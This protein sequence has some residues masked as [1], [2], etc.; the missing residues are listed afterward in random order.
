MDRP[1]FF[2]IDSSAVLILVFRLLRCYRALDLNITLRGI[3]FWVVCR[4]TVRR[5]SLLRLHF[6]AQLRIPSRLSP[7]ELLELVHKEDGAGSTTSDLGFEALRKRLG[8]MYLRKELIVLD[9]CLFEER[10]ISLP[11]VVAHEVAHC[12][13]EQPNHFPSDGNFKLHRTGSDRIHWSDSN[14]SEI[15]AEGKA[16]LPWPYCC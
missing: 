7:A 1:K 3:P 9:R 10:Q 12:D 6:Q 13:M 15:P 5:E 14:E 4:S 11:F 8:R 16:F 2:S